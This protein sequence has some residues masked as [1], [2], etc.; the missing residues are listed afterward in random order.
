MDASCLLRVH[1]FAAKVSALRN[2][3]R[4]VNSVSC[5]VEVLVEWT[6]S[7]DIPVV[8]AS[9]LHGSAEMVVE[10]LPHGSA[11]IWD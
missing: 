2:K 11:D 10:I 4:L 3:I 6:A 8:V 9:S 7:P 1:Y 5:T